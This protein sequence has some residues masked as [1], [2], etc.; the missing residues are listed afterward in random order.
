MGNSSSTPEN[1][2][3][4]L[5]SIKN[6]LDANTET[7]NPLKGDKSVSETSEEEYTESNVNKPFYNEYVE[8]KQKYLASKGNMTGGNL[9]QIILNNY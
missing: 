8:A 1:M 4:Q 2:Q 3:P 5:N 6:I 9:R 7:Y